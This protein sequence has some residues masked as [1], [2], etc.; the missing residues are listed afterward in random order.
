MDFEPW[1]VRFCIANVNY[2]T[3]YKKKG[4]A[5]FI[6]AMKTQTNHTQNEQLPRPFKTVLEKG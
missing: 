6:R 4:Y 5:S 2:M 1:P 3:G